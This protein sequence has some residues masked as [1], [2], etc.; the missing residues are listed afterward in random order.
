MQLLLR[1][2]ALIEKKFKVSYETK[3]EF[4]A[5]VRDGKNVARLWNAW[6]RK[7]QTS[8]LQRHTQAIHKT[9]KNG[10]NASF[11]QTEN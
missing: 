2:Y 11:E 6:E 1:Y 4:G 5:I 10:S 8:L 9:S 3:F 7:K